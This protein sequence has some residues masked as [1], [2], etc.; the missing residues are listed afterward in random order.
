MKQHHLGI[1]LSG[2]KAVLTTTAPRLHYCF[3]SSI[4]AMLYTDTPYQSAKCGTSP[5]STQPSSQC[6][7]C[8]CSTS[9]PSVT[10]ATSHPRPESS[11]ASQSTLIARAPVE[12]LCRPACTHAAAQ[13]AP[14][15]A[16]F[17][18]KD[19]RFGPQCRMNCRGTAAC[20]PAIGQTRGNRDQIL[21]ST[22]PCQTIRPQPSSIDNT[23]N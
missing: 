2:H 9:S 14:P 10:H 13:E 8:P 5:A 16:P 15:L 23:Y 4:H 22:E 17:H 18:C 20:Q 6:S 3:K 19:Q 21:T 7:R 1:C 12:E 11:S